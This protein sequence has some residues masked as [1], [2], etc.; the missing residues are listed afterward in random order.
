MTN[1]G[2]ME[3]HGYGVL[4]DNGERLLELCGMER[5]GY[6]ALNDNGERLLEFY[7]INNLR[8]LDALYSRTR[9]YT[10]IKIKRNEWL[11]LIKLSLYKA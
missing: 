8:L 1:E 10:G 2:V 6:G 7:S 9:T 3:R 11:F 5:H 4:N